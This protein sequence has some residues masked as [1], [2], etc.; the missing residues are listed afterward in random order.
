MSAIICSRC[1][2]SFASHTSRALHLVECASNAAEEAERF[3]ALYDAS[4]AKLAAAEAENA[5]L[6]EALACLE[7]ECR[8][9]EYAEFIADRLEGK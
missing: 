7:E 4:Q 5:R 1:K 3:M 8:L 2:E 6:R 9:D